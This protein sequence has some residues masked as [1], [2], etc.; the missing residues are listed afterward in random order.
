MSV[1][2]IINEQTKFHYKFIIVSYVTILLICILAMIPGGAFF[3][4][5]IGSPFLL[6]T[7]Y[8]GYLAIKMNRIINGIFIIL[9]SI[10]V[11]PIFI[12][13]ASIFST[14][15]AALAELD[16]AVK[17]TKEISNVQKGNPIVS[18]NSRVF[19]SSNNNKTNTSKNKRFSRELHWHAKNGNVDAVK[20]Y[21]ESKGDIN[22]KNDLGETPLHWAASGGNREI[23]EMLIDEGADINEVSGLGNTPLDLAISFNG[24]SDNKEVIEFLLKKGA[25]QNRA[26]F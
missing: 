22:I 19:K 6:L 2:P 13:F 20:K 18:S 7:F 11:A 21:L 1:P 26:P 3:S 23:V 16:K 5:L 25:R 15:Y 8:I 24:L 4:F 10:F 17:R 14:G 12:I 9:L